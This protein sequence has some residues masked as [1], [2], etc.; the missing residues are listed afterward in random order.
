MS[1][2]ATTRFYEQRID[3][4]MVTAVELNDLVAS[5][6]AARESNA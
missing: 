3:V 4:S 5:G 2:R 6:E 1:K